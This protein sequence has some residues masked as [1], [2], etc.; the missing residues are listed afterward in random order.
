MKMIYPKYW[1]MLRCRSKRGLQFTTRDHVSSETS[2]EQPLTFAAAFFNIEILKS[3][4]AEWRK[5]LCMPRQVCVD[6]GREFGAATNVFYKPPCVSV[7]RCGGCCNRE[8]L[9]CKNISTSYISKTLF[10]ITV[11]VTK[12][13][14]PV[15]INFANHTSCRCLS[16]EDV[17]R[18]MHSIIRRSLAD[19]NVENKTCPENHIWNSHLCR[20]VI[21]HSSLPSQHS[22]QS[23]FTDVCGPDQEL[24]DDTCQVTTQML[25]AREKVSACNMQ[26]LPSTL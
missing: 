5:T 21:Q 14:K 16:K 20:C 4:D 17:Q 2:T 6:V 19:C 22:M 25:L 13:T 12:G 24:D 10:E 1:T 3:I 23:F 8:E 26:L 18:Q 15:T 9:Q 11:P 7:Y